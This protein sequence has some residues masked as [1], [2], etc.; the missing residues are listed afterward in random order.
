MIRARD[1]DYVAVFT[2]TLCPKIDI[3][4]TDYV[5]GSQLNVSTPATRRPVALACST[6]FYIFALA[7]SPETSHSV[8]R[9]Y[10][11]G[12]R[13]ELQPFLAPELQLC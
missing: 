9:L 6:P 10:A 3:Y 2:W 1:S 13:T 5:V 7:G 11:R 8:S 12:G 4:T